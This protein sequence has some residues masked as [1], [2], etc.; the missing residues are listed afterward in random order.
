MLHLTALRK[1]RRPRGQAVVEF[2]LVLPILLLLLA[3]AIDLGR[4]SYAY[5]AVQN[6]A[7]EGALYG[8]RSPL[9]DDNTNPACPDPNNVVWHV[10]NEASN[11]KDGSGNSLLTATV[12]CRD[13]AGALVQPINNCVDG[14]T[15]QVT[16][17]YPFTLITP[18]LSSIMGSGF[19]LR[20][21]SQATVISDAFDPTGLEALIWVD[22]AG[23][24][25]A[26][27]IAS[28][29]TQADA[30]TSPNY[31]YQACQD[32]SNV[33][34]FLQFQEN[35]TV[36]YKVR[37][38]NTGNINLTGLSYAFTVN[39]ASVAKPGNCSTLP[40]TMNKGAAPSYCTFT[41]SATSIN[42]GNG[43]DDDTVTITASGTANGL[44]TG[45][46][47]G[48]ATIKVAPAPHL[49]INLKASQY[50]LGG[51]GFGTAG[52]PTYSLGGLTLD[53]NAAS[54]VT[55]IKN[56]T[57]WFYLTVVNQG[58]VA[59]NFTV[60][61]TQQGAG[62]TLPG[63]CVVPTTLAA[64]GQSGDTFTCIFPRT[65]NA[66]QA[67]ALVA[68]AS[69]TNAVIVG[70]Q[71]PAVTATTATCSGSN[72]VIPNLVDTLAPSAD[73]TNKTVGQSRTTWQNAGFTG[74][75]TTTPAGG[76]NG[77]TTFTQ[78]NRVAYTCAATNSAVNVG[79]Q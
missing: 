61:V 28:V 67:Y 52:T 5:V 18:I 65:F 44:P 34:N 77:L 47:A 78:N 13:S 4:F 58:G 68:T 48:G 49:A 51:T 62:I 29:C 32:T 41:R 27:A 35:T 40:T 19:T 73:G 69:A 15:Y 79:A 74:A 60:S 54:V 57:G 9:C 20:A 42:P 37:V 59:N 50:R 25:N 46:T 8:A 72:A 33:D 43:I 16:V 55:E 10:A 70:G 63:S 11:L 39:G 66:T 38:R 75:L 36:N 14:N 1:D 6:A 64:S 24:S 23:A 56:P 21:E 2:V 30:A 45:Q 31:Y 3:A 76:A 22:K 26:A 7:K 17:S 71:Q 12:A 53:R